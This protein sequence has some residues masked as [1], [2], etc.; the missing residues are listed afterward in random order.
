MSSH[1][2]EFEKL[3]TVEQANKMLPLVRAIVA[4]LQRLYLEL[5]E[6][7]RRLDHLNTGRED[8][9]EDPYS[10]EL[11]AIDVQLEVDR[12]RLR[13]YVQELKDLGVECKD[14]GQGLVDFPA[15]MDDDIVYL[16]WKLDEPEVLHWHHLEAGFA[17]RKPLTAGAVASEEGGDLEDAFGDD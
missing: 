15:E 7:Q 12:R 1:P 9:A 14:P 2:A 13:D 11:R 5:V 4:D 17:G 3:F 6:R 16:C 8:D 10:D